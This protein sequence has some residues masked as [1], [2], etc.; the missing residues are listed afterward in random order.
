MSKDGKENLSPEKNQGEQERTLSEMD[1]DELMNAMSELY[2]EKPRPKDF[3]VRLKLI[4][5]A[6][7]SL[8]KGEEVDENTKVTSS[9]SRTTSNTPSSQPGVEWD[10]EAGERNQ[11]RLRIQAKRTQPALLE[12][13][14]TL[15]QFLKT[16]LGQKFIEANGQWHYHE[17]KVGQVTFVDD[18]QLQL[19]PAFEESLRLRL[20]IF[21]SSRSAD[22]IVKYEEQPVE[23]LRQ[24]F[25]QCGDMYKIPE[26]LD[27][28]ERD[29]DLDH[30]SERSKSSAVRKI[31]DAGPK[32]KKAKNS[33]SGHDFGSY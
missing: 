29:H 31:V 11:A 20:K 5:D 1:F 17:T 14:S 16:D 4:G 21:V 12:L 6:M 28:V 8:P 10:Y 32:D 33:S 9:P 30:E 15:T 23:L 13:Q 24:F 7:D 2:R 3:D 22:A 18:S 26:F 19:N 27:G 25:H